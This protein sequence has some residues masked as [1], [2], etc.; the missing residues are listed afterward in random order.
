MAITAVWKLLFK[1]YAANTLFTSSTHH[2]THICRLKASADMAPQA[3]NLFWLT[4]GNLSHD[5]LL[6]IRVAITCAGR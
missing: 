3:Q 1:I 2:L 5:L 6:L 4:T